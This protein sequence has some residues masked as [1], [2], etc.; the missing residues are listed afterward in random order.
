MNEL[1]N[2]FTPLTVFPSPAKNELT[3]DLSGFYSEV[4]LFIYDVTGKL[5]S[6][7]TANGNAYVT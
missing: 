1:D 5:V 7:Q 6:E 3:I 2:E 4:E